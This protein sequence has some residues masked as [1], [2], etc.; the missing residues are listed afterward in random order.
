MWKLFTGPQKWKRKKF[1]GCPLCATAKHHSSLCQMG[2]R[3][4]VGCARSWPKRMTPILEDKEKSALETGI[5]G[6]GENIIKQVTI[7]LGHEK[8]VKYPQVERLLNREVQTQGVFRDPQV[9]LIELGI[10]GM[11]RET[12]RGNHDRS[13][14]MKFELNLIV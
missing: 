12:D 13:S 4:L 5:K 11:Q 2:A 8:S 9:I 1:I 14:L 7:K 3:R 10:Y 6:V